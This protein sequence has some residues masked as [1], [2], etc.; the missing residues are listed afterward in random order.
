MLAHPMHDFKRKFHEFA[1]YLSSLDFPDCWCID[2][3]DAAT[4]EFYRGDLFDRHRRDRDIWNSLLS[5]HKVYVL[6]AMV[7]TMLTASLEK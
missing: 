2:P 3:V 6:H 7:L 5:P 1:H 4:V